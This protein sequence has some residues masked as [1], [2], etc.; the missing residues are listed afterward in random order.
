[1]NRSY[2]D[3]TNFRK[4]KMFDPMKI[5]TIVNYKLIDFKISPLQHYSVGISF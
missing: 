4:K 3:S 1:M 5:E 2:F